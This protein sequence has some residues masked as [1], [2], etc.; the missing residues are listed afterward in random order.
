MA[1]EPLAVATAVANASAADGGWAGSSC[2]E[3]A[4]GRRLAER[5]AAAIARL[6]PATW[7]G[8]S[9]LFDGDAADSGVKGRGSESRSRLWLA[10]GDTR[11]SGSSPTLASSYRISLQLKSAQL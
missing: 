4:C 8:S 1:F 9:V 10:G 11:G 6:V 2:W 3:F 5:G 7:R